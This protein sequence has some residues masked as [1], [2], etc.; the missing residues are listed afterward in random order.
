M[1]NTLAGTNEAMVGG[2]GK[3]M[4][5]SMATQTRAMG[6]VLGT[7]ESKVGNYTLSFDGAV[8]HGVPDARYVNSIFDNAVRQL[9][10]SSRSWAFNPRGQ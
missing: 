3:T 5:D 9:R 1:T 7:T 8:F 4:R 6:Q 10:T 2:F